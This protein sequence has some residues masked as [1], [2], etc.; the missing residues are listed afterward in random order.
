MADLSLDREML[1]ALLI[2]NLVRRLNCKLNL[3]EERV[4]REGEIVNHKDLP[5][6]SCG[7]AECPAKE[8]E[9]ADPKVGPTESGSL[10]QLSL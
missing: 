1:K 6:L 3:D 7:R 9:A 2:N 10:L 5:R 4:R 8:R